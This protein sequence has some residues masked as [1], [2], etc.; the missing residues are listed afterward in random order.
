M[1]GVSY[2]LIAM[3]ICLS[4]LIAGAAVCLAGQAQDEVK[5][6][7][8]IFEG[9]CAAC[10]G[11]HGEGGRGPTLRVPR[12]RHAPDDA[13]LSDLLQNG[14]PGTGMPGFF[15]SE[16]ETAQVTAY[17]H[18]LGRQPA[19][20]AAGDA[21]RGRALF[22]AKGCGGCHIAEGAGQPFGPDLNE[23]GARRNLDYLRRVLADPASALPEAFLLVR[24]VIR[25][26]EEVQGMRINEDSFTIQ[27]RDR[28]AALHSFRKGELSNLIREPGKTWMPSYAGL[29]AAEVDDL[30][31]YLGGLRGLP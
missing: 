4:L 1:S 25:L 9:Q 24:A 22:Q 29:S 13:A 28:G 15:L 8:R 3:R 21:V 16:D 14:I 30:L 31:A 19:L 10:H 20:P 2:A 5:L 18:S 7:Q 12:L 27:I 6:G 17:I 11:I 26:G 23:V